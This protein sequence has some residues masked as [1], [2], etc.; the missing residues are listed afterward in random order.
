[1][2]LV[3]TRY[4]KIIKDVYLHLLVFTLIYVEFG[5]RMVVTGLVSGT[6]R[7]LILL[8]ATAPLIFFLKRFDPKRTII[9]VY[10][11]TLI[12]FNSL[13]GDSFENCI[14]LFIPI[15]IGYIM[16]STVKIDEF[17]KTFNNV[18]FYLS[19][20]SLFVFAVS[21]IA[22]SVIYSLPF[23]GYHLDTY[24]TK[25]YD[26]LFSV[27]II[28]PGYIRNAGITWEPGAFAVLLS[29]ALCSML[30]FEKKRKP[31]RIIV[32]I[33]A[34]ITTFSTMGY[35][36]LAGILLAFVFQ[37]GRLNAKSRWN[38]FLLLAVIVAVVLCLPK[39]I[40]E[41]VFSKLEGLFSDDSVDIAETTQARID[42]IKYP[43]AAFMESPIFG[44]G[45]ENFAFLNATLCHGVAT[46]TILNWFAAMGLLMGIPCTYYYFKLIFVCGKKMRLYLPGILILIVSLVL[47]ISTES[48]LRISLIYILIFYGAGNSFAGDRIKT[49]YVK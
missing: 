22:P 3:E 5:Y 40:Y 43:F 8:F 20:F 31:V 41:L 36:T 24:S 12:A 44:I 6:A 29:V 4:F 35:F 47:P 39:D 33:I 2:K 32:F 26:A 30:V 10:L 38:F 49:R 28:N 9:F 25:V 7:T 19:L 23:I 11:T 16:A 48:L 15:Y 42:A 1:M 18:M 13:R 17:A 21:L 27:A 37:K 34:L 14:I 46:N 45:Y